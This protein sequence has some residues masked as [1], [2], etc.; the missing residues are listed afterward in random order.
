MKKILII[1]DNLEV[2]ENLAE[3]LELSN[4]DVTTAE[5]GKIGVAKAAE[6]RPDLI[7]CDVMMPELDGFGAL[8]ILSKNPLTANIPFIFLTAKAEK[9]D[10]RKGM[11]LGADDYIT[12][13]F[14][15]AELLEAIE[16]RLKKGEILQQNF[17]QSATGLSDFMAEARAREALTHLAEERETRKYD[18]KATLYEEGQY[19]KAVYF[20]NSG[21]I[22][23]SKSDDYGKSLTTNLYSTGDFIG[24]TALIKDQPYEET[25]EILEAA[26]LSIIPKDEFLDL[27]YTNRDVS[28]RFIRM[29]A[30]N[31]AEKEAQLLH[32]A[33][34]SVRKR[35]A[36]ALVLLHKKYNDDATKNFSISLLRD[37]LA[38]IVGTAKETVIRTLR[39]FKDDQLI[40]I[41]G[42]T[43]TILDLDELK[44]MY[45]WYN[46]LAHV[47]NQV[48][49]RKCPFELRVKSW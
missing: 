20:V 33:Y 31:L 40:E 45:N 46:V 48:E 7:I 27:L 22:K 26:E 11:N 47:G 30:N 35:V 6:V 12:K 1:E 24:T 14:D 10:F 34:D 25:A 16:I 2:R 44:E 13:P 17:E 38:A 39:E 19:P 32:L 9:T 15:D 3:I 37:D 28:H 42:S 18:K 49:G 8:R 5:N 21:K 36:D 4:Y 23:G 41:K 29:L 43:I